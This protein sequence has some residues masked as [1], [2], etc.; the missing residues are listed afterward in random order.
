MPT[1]AGKTLIAEL[2]IFNALSQHN[3]LDIYIVPSIALTNEIENNFFKRFHKVGIKVRKEVPDTEGLDTDTFWE[4]STILI[5][6]PEKLDLLIRKK[7][8]IMSSIQIIVFDE[9]HK[10]SA[11][12]RGWL[13]ETLIAWFILFKE[14][15]GY[16]VVLM[17]AILSHVENCI[18][19]SSIDI[20]CNDWTPTRK[21]YGLYNL[22]K[23]SQVIYDKSKVPKRSI[24]NEPYDL[25]LIYDKKL[26]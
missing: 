10:V 11:D 12:E 15:Y 19:K 17:S 5:L 7:P 1:S 14:N 9:F 25:Y 2:A 20:I 26:K 8:D 22:H 16:R 4:G 18:D 24:I 6:T 3:G 23:K 13:L 21:L